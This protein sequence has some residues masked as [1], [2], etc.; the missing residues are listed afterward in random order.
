[1]PELTEEQIEFLDEVCEGR[2]YWKLNSKGEVDVDG[3]VII[4]DFYISGEIPVKFGEVTGCF[5]CS[6]N[7]LTTLKNFPEYIGDCI[8]LQG[9]N[10]TDYFKSIKE[11]DFDNW[12]VLDWFGILR[13]Y[14]FLINIS[15]NYISTKQL[16]EYLKEFP[17]TKLYY[18]D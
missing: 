10:L 4:P 11:E 6:N 13:E 12:Y 7:N 16:P 9:N 3:A 17:L 1:M 18:R 8:Y 15:K 5:N 2:K 14:P